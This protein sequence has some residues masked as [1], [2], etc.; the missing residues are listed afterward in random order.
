M[1]DRISPIVHGEFALPPH[2][3]GKATWIKSGQR[4]KMSEGR[5]ETESLVARRTATTLDV[6]DA[7]CTTAAARP[8]AETGSMTTGTPQFLSSIVC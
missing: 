3:T 7:N 6:K 8:R 2:R 4:L 1:A 5:P